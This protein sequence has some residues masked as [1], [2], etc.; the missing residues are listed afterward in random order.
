[1]NIGDVLELSKK[2]AKSKRNSSGRTGTCRRTG[3]EAIIGNIVLRD[4]KRTFSE[5]G[6]MVVVVTID[7]ASGTILAGPDIISEVL[8]MSENPRILWRKPEP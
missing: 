6:L 2:D 5:N 7:S 3:R 1:M 8:Y 4:R